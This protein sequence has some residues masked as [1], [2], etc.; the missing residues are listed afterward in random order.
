MWR[1]CPD[2]SG[3]LQSMEQDTHL[4]G[5]GSKRSCDGTI[6]TLSLCFKTYLPHGSWGFF[7][8]KIN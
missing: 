4:L 5:A 2:M 8:L 6:G 1:T 7:M 3:D